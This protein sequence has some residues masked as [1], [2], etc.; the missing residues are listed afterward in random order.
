VHANDTARERDQ[1][2]RAK[3][4]HRLQQMCGVL[5]QTCGVCAEL[6]AAD[7]GDA[8]ADAAEAGGGDGCTASNAC[9]PA[10]LELLV[11]SL[12]EECSLPDE[13][14]CC[15]S[16]GKLY[17]LPGLIV[18]RN[19]PARAHTQEIHPLPAPPPPPPLSHTHKHAHTHT[20]THTNTHGML[21]I[22]GGACGRHSSE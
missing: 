13:S 17:L 21:R 9:P 22:I 3:A 16:L 8:D 1:A 7:A 10:A 18:R 5:Q 14:T 11:P 15:R 6:S 4:A 2:K 12:Q 20:H 19:I